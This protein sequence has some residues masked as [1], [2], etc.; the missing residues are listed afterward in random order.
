MARNKKLIEV[1]NKRIIA[2]YKALTNKKEHGVQL[3]SFQAI[4]KKLEHEFCI[5]SDYIAKI[6]NKTE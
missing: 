1:R 3:Y 5:T 2:K 4:M 6:I